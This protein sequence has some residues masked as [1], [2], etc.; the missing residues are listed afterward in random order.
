M[1][2]FKAPYSRMDH[3]IGA[4]MKTHMLIKAIAVV[5]LAL[6]SA[7]SA[8]DAA[9]PS[10]AEAPATQPAANISADARE[11]IDQIGQAYGK[12]TALNLTGTDSVRLQTE[13]STPQNHSADFTSSFVAPNKFRHEVKG[14]VL[15]GSTGQKIYAFKSED[16][17]YTM[18]DAPK[19]RA[20]SKE[21]PR[22]IA[23]LLEMQDPSLALAISKSAS[24]ELVDG[25][26]EASK[27]SGTKIGDT[28][29]PTLKFVQKDK[30]IITM[31]VDPATHLLRQMTV[32]L[33]PTLKERRPDLSSA[34]VTVD[35][36]KTT[37]DRPDKA[38][39]FAWTSPEGARDAA[40]MAAAQQPNDVAASELEGK[41]APAFKLDGLDG[42]AVSLADLKGKVVIIDFWATWCGPCRA[43]LPHLDKLYQSEKEKG[44]KVF[45]LDQ[46]EE[47]D[48]VKQFVEKTK[49]SV[50]VL[51]DS[52]SKVGAAY[53]VTGIPQTVVIGKDGK[54]KKIFIGFDPGSSPEELQR[55]VKSAM[56]E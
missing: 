10:A 9:K 45:A 39:L 33:T 16:N 15:V 11:L 54:I 42:K 3:L 14:D 44:L 13:G 40:E 1:L 2:M 29:Y 24:D 52:D 4:I 55:A 21:L 12:L 48:A 5:T 49:L 6:G 18:A 22:T 56:K 19:D 7:V 35:Y 26:V 36:A 37:A 53:G 46:S 30:S 17:A 32:D 47:Q 43:S 8:E 51:L 28:D 27:I 31:A 34:V 23:G 41:A 38:E 50:P 25:I 20:P